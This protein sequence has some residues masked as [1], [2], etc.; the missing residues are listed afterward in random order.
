MY[1]HGTTGIHIL[2][3]KVKLRN[4]SQFRNLCGSEVK[5]LVKTLLGQGLEAGIGED[6]TL[7]LKGNLHLFFPELLTRNFGLL[8]PKFGLGVLDNRSRKKKYPKF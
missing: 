7:F 2:S 8:S 5:S 3:V 1:M 6:F 4:F